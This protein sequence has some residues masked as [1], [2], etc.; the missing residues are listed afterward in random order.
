[1]KVTDQMQPNIFYDAFQG[2]Q[3]YNL[4]ALSKNYLH[5][6]IIVVTRLHLKSIWKLRRFGALSKAAFMQAEQADGNLHTDAFPQSPWKFCTI[7]A[8]ESAEQM[9]AYA[10][11]GAHAEAMKHHKDLAKGIQTITY[12]S[13]TIP[14]RK[15]ARSMLDNRSNDDRSK[16]NS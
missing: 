15:E 16:L 3:K 4:S 12:E 2:R 9:K 14:E 10:R 5:P 13:D 7:T 6:M 11:S 8:W 1:M